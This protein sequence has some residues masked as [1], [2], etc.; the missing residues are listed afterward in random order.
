MHTV[1]VFRFFLLFIETV[2]NYKENTVRISV[3]INIL[4]LSSIYPPVFPVKS[5]NN[6]LHWITHVT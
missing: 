4:F 3:L 6:H 5:Y 2:D 1:F